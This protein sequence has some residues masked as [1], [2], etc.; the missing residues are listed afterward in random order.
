MKKLMIPAIMACSLCGDAE[1][2]KARAYEPGAYGKVKDNPMFICWREWDGEI[3]L[4]GVAKGYSTPFK[5]GDIGDYFAGEIQGQ[6]GS[7]NW[8]RLM[9]GRGA[10]NILLGTNYTGTIQVGT[11]FYNISGTSL[12]KGTK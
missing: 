12:T 8:E 3:R 9:I 7:A 2:N 6:N 11:N 5:L 10:T 4:G 1:P